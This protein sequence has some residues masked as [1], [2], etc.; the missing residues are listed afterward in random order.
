MN[1]FDSLDVAYLLLERSSL[2]LAE[3]LHAV[4]LGLRVLMEE[5]RLCVSAGS[6]D[7]AAAA[8]MAKSRSSLLRIIVIAQP[9]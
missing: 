9:L 3:Q 8:N 4:T 5:G 1:A 2:D 7:S 6:F